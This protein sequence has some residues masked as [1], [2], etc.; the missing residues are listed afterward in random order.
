MVV[1]NQDSDRHRPTGPNTSDCRTRFTT[2][3]S[4]LTQLEYNTVFLSRCQRPLPRLFC[5]GNSN[6]HYGSRICVRQLQRSAKFFN[7]LPHSANAHAHIARAKSH[8]VFIKSLTVVAYFNRNTL[9]IAHECDRTVRGFRMSEDVGQGFLNNSKN[10]SLE[11]WCQPRESRWSHIKGG[12]N[13][14]AFRHALQVPTQ[15]R[16]Q[17]DLI[18]QGWMQ[19]MRHG[20]NL[21]Q[22]T[23]NTLAGLQRGLVFRIRGLLMSYPV[24]RHFRRCEILAQTVV[25]LASDPAALLIL[26][27]H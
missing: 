11:T 6:F 10:R 14:T 26:H 2:T 27:A 16:D 3:P 25:K 15:G 22:R 5:D 7:A 8:C 21:L 23:I 17:P 20:T 18:E 24:N 19:E 12:L 9:S 1:G 4:E 13:A